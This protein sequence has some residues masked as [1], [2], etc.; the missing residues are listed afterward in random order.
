LTY[1]SNNLQGKTYLVTGASK[2]IGRA[3]A[4]L[5]SRCGGSVI[6][7]GRNQERLERTLGEM[8]GSGHMVIP[9][10]LLNPDAV[11]ELANECSELSGIVHSAGVSRVAPIRYTTDKLMREMAAANVDAPVALTRELIKSQQLLPGGSIVF[12]S[13]LSAIYGWTGYVA[14]S[15]SKAALI[16]VTRALASE[17]SDKGIRCNCL[18]P[19]MIKTPMLKGGFSEAKLKEEEDKYPFGFGKPIDVANA[20]VFF[21]SDA[22]SWI[23]G[24]T[25]VL[26]GGVS[27]K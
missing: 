17:L 23:T 4:K 3:T 12:I 1:A 18:A 20:I 16:G 27:L 25:L 10:D 13:S 6:I 24:Q 19:G 14:Y 8:K 22:S 2:G 9:S 21:L 7:S 15:A 5:I 26:D 11:K